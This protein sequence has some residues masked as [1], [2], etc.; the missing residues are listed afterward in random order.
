VWYFVRDQKP[1]G[2]ISAAEIE[3]LIRSGQITGNTLVWTNPMKD[4][5]AVQD[6]AALSALLP[7]QPPPLPSPG[8]IASTA[9]S[10]SLRPDALERILQ[11][12]IPLAGPWSRFF[13]RNIDI[14]LAVLVMVIVIGILSATHF[15]QI[16]IWMDSANEAVL[17]LVIFT[18]AMLMTAIS[19][20]MFGTTI[21]K[22]LFGIR[23]RNLTEHG[24]LRFH[25]KRELNV[26][27]SG[28]ALGIPLFA[29]VTNVWQFR[30]LSANLPA[31]YDEGRARVEA[32][33]LSLSRKFAAVA[34][35]VLFFAGAIALSAWGE[36][37][38]ET[39]R[40]AQGW[41]NPVTGKLVHISGS[42]AVEE[43]KAERGKLYRFTSDYFLAEA[44]FGTEQAGPRLI[45]A[46]RYGEALEAALSDDLR[47]RSPWRPVT[48]SGRSAMRAYATL[49]SDS[50]VDIQ[51]T[52]AVVGDQ[53]WRTLIF[54]RGRKI[55]E[56][57][58]GEDFVRA[59]FSSI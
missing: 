52:V 37:E 50:N 29:L 13:A 30:R 6:T 32:R 41:L 21:G 58:F 23:V 8:S 33:K 25:L 34:V 55:D 45:D 7:Q 19:M 9:Y 12:D 5:K 4:W 26:W 57:A 20:T 38:D 36:Q 14:W 51:L 18:I 56:A 10:S 35:Y 40:K 42:W 54:A 46:S 17:G 48:V 31:S 15:P 53:A 2:P 22:A 47:F 3:N 1:A 16:Q 11:A 44:L 49:G 43:E 27:V 24:S 59:V 28:M 39:A